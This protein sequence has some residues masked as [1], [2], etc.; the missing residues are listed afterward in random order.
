MQ[1]KEN[2]FYLLPKKVFFLLHS[3][4]THKANLYSSD[5]QHDLFMPIKEPLDV[6]S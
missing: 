6:N 4:G 2:L 5:Y 3:L 1:Q